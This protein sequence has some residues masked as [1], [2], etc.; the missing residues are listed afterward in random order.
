MFNVTQKYSTRCKI[1]RILCTIEIIK[2]S[3]EEIEQ[4]D[5]TYEN[6]VRKR[7][8]FRRNVFLLGKTYQLDSL[9]NINLS[10]DEMSANISI[11]STAENFYVSL[12]WWILSKLIL[13]VH[14]YLANISDTVKKKVHF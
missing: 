11:V 6:G 8:N 10:L 9:G 14:D 12:K 1:C 13:T 3:Q 5:L 2:F 7:T 4:M